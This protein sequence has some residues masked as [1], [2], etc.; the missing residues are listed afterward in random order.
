M[1]AH[2]KRQ[3][4][5]KT[6]PIARKGNTFVVKSKSKGLPLLVALRDIL[7]LAQTKKEVKQAIHKKD[8][9]ISGKVANDEK[10]SIE[11]LDIL[12]IIPA[13]ENYRLNLSKFG[14]YIFEKIDEKD[15]KTKIAKI[16]GKKSIKGKKTQINLFDGR[17]Y[18]SKE[19]C[20]V[21]DSVVIDF[22]KS[23]ISKVL[24]LKEK[25]NILV[26]GGK[27]AGATGKIETLVPQLKMAE[28]NDGEKK[29]RVLIKQLMVIN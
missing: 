21:N 19:K 22:S 4:V 2:L 15:T 3:K 24:Q 28:I 23:K 20:E 8:I 12:T 27:H 10:N 6:W 1:K 11:L 16:I 25:S 9:L 13:K 5:P 29:F 7:K 18:L 17:N 14:K 26:I